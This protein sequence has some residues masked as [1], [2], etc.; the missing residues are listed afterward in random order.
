ML[1]LQPQGNIDALLDPTKLYRFVAALASKQG[2]TAWTMG[3][4]SSKHQELRASNDD[5]A[6]RDF[7]AAKTVVIACHL[8]NLSHFQDSF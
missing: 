4:C 7:Q 6:D 1:A 5:R 3:A 2:A 8:I